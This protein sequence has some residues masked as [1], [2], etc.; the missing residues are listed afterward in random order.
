[1]S[2]QMYHLFFSAK[3]AELRRIDGPI[4]VPYY[5]TKEGDWVEATEVIPVTDD[6]SI[7]TPTANHDD[8]QYLGIGVH[9][10]DD[11]SGVYDSND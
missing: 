5:E 4:M 6:K 3:Q 7:P 2:V 8:A 9:H 11:Y 1:M 10:H